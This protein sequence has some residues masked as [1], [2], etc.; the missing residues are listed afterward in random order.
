MTIRRDSRLVMALL[1]VPLFVLFHPQIVCAQTTINGSSLSHRSSGNGTGDWTLGE[2][3][4]VGTYITLIEPGPVTLKVNASGLSTDALAAHMNLVVADHKVG[5]EVASDFSDFEHTFDLPAG[6][7]FVRTEFNNETPLARRQL[8]VG[9]LTV[10]GATVSNS[11]SITTNDANALAAADTYIENYRKGP[12]Q[13]ELLGATP[14]TPVHV[15]LK[16]HDFRFGTAVGGTSLNG[17]NNYLNNSNYTGFLLDH[18]NTITQGNAGKWAYNEGTRDVVTMAA[19]D[20]ML[21]FAEDNNLDVR[22]HN[23][24]WGDSQQPNWVNTLLNNA[25]GGSQTAKDDLRM[26]ISERIDHYV[27][28][29]DGNTSDDRARRYVEMD[30]LNE[31]SHQPKYWD[32]YGAEGIA[33][34]FTEASEAVTAAG[35]DAKLYLNEYNVFAWGDSYGNWYRQDVEEIVNNGGAVGGIG[36]QYY[37]SANSNPQATHSP[38]RMNQILQGLSV[39]GLDISLTEFGVGTANGTTVENAA[40]YLEDTMRLVFGSANAT[41]FMMWGFW[42]NDVWNQAPLAA[43]RDASW[44]PTVP[45]VAYDTLMSEW[46]TDITLPVGPDGTVDFAGFFGEYEITIDGETFDLVHTKGTSDYS[47]LVA[48]PGDF[49]DN[50]IVN[51]ADLAIWQAGYGLDGRGDADGDGDTDGRDF[52]IWQRNF[53]PSGHLSNSVS[54]PEPS[55]LAL[56]AMTLLFWNRPSRNSSPGN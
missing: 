27:G 54:V 9:S 15:K 49:D 44:N 24:L 7:Y 21:Q 28:N 50:L 34:M 12:A 19:V 47:L 43:L 1:G 2:N 32:V 48:V 14:G 11:T 10:S 35:S 31:H 8:T 41:T 40:T 30:L 6:T 53:S 25:D 5:F 22:L 51:A 52:S 16:Q 3:G 29:G 46:N 20:R 4:Y 26:E 56:M 55:C 17:V 13:I 23:M 36:I 33:E 37:P 18:F 42:A 39:T 45:G 38:A